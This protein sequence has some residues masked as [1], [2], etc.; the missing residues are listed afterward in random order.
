MTYRH[1]GDLQ[2]THSPARGYW[3]F[4]LH[5]EPPGVVGSALNASQR[6]D[7]SRSRYAAEWLDRLVPCDPDA[8]HLTLVGPSDA[9]KLWHPCVHDDPDSPS[10]VAR[11]GC[12]CWQTLRD[13]LTWLPVAAH[14]YR[15][16]SG[17]HEHWQHCT[18]AP[19]SLP[20][21]ERLDALIIDREA[22]MIWARSNSGALH[23]LPEEQ[24]RGYNVGYGGGGPTEL[25]RMV[26]KIVKSD[27]TDIT[28][29]TPTEMPNRRV[30]SWVSSKAAD[31][32]QELTL[33][34]LK[35][36]CRTG[37]TE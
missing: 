13:P 18:Y 35:L 26:E 4:V 23:I 33:D 37:T 28:P 31:H 12:V 27:G 8:L 32:T 22:H 3:N 24:G 17:N 10:A 7:A 1:E 15:T 19:L 2:L 21:G 16:A 11:E 6:F 9:P 36:L 30:H 14:H 20:D 34:Q 25:A 5:I 29:G